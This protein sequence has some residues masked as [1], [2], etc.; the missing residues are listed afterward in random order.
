VWQRRRDA[1]PIPNLAYYLVVNVRVSYLPIRQKGQSFAQQ[2]WQ[3]SNPRP[4][5]WS[6]LSV[7]LDYT[8]S[9]GLALQLCNRPRNTKEP[10]PSGS[11]SSTNWTYVCPSYAVEGTSRWSVATQLKDWAFNIW[12]MTRPRDGRRPLR[13]SDG[14]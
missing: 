3:E 11:G 6:R 5:G 13:L 10:P 7:P 14:R 8:P 2:G 9:S 1:V 4:P 12:A